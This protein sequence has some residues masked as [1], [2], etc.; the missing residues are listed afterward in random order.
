MPRVPILSSDGN[1]LGQRSVSRDEF[2]ARLHSAIFGP[3]V[4]VSDSMR[5]TG[6][7]IRSHARRGTTYGSTSAFPSS[8]RTRGDLEYRDYRTSGSR[9]SLPSGARHVDPSLD[10]RG[11][12][13]EW[14]NSD[15]VD[16]DISRYGADPDVDP[17]AERRFMRD[18]GRRPGDPD[19]VGDMGLAGVDSRDFAYGRGSVST[20]SGRNGYASPMGTRSIPLDTAVV[21][22]SRRL[23]AG[24]G[25]RSGTHRGHRSSTM[26]FLDGGDERYYDQRDPR[27]R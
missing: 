18:L 24:T 27:R 20:R 21:G 23:T 1:Y 2:P 15:L 8:S 17:R 14:R 5:T 25:S 4:S 7:D 10:P 26:D 12:R 19:S 22:S 16:A 9:R 13:G 11:N 6:D 3:G